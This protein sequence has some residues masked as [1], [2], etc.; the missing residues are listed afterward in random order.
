MK[1]LPSV[2]FGTSI[3]AFHFHEAIIAH[4][5]SWVNKKTEAIASVQIL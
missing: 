1:I 5:S 3:T 2:D 4:K